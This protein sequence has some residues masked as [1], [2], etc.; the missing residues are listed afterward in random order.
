MSIATPMA[1]WEAVTETPA[2]TWPASGY[3][4]GLRGNV[5][6]PTIPSRIQNA[7]AAF[8]VARKVGSGRRIFCASTAY[9]ERRGAP[10]V[11]EDLKHH[12]CIVSG[13]STDGASWTFKS[14][15]G[16]E[17]VPVAGRLA[18]NVMSLAI[19]AAVAGLGIAQVPE[20]LAMPDVRAGRLV[21]VLDPFVVDRTGL[22][23]V[24]PSSRQMS[25]AV[26]AFIDHV[27]D[28]AAHQ[29]NLKS[30]PKGLEAR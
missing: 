20:G 16:P 4:S 14:P 19:V 25:A 1:G 11:P 26:R 3:S 27:S 30:E 2:P 12:D 22:Y 24:F 21:Q 18:V 13:D 28:W 10:T 29:L 6:G 7:C 9:L 5:D 23:L 15:D 17:T 8:L